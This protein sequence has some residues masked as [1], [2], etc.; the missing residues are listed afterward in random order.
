[1]NGATAMS[2]RSVAGRATAA[3]LMCF[4]AAIA[5]PPAAAAEVAAN[6]PVKLKIAF[7]GDSLVD[8][9]WSGV[10]RIVGASACLRNAIELGRYAKNG[11]GLTR[12]DRLYWPRE[13]RRIGEVFKPTVIVV[14]LGVND[15]QFIVDGAGRHTAWG[16]PDWPAKYRGEVDDFLEGAAA[17]GAT[18]L[19]VGLP[20]MREPV[21]NADARGKNELYAAEIAKLGDRNIEYV[22]PW[23][24]N[25][26]GGDAFASFGPDRSGRMVQIR[27]SDGQHFTT[28]GEDLAAAHIYPK[29]VAALSRIGVRFEQCPNLEARKEN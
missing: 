25:A 1:M 7:A 15:R 28:A 18:V 16:S 21:D 19:W 14:S 13:I 6:G 10:S 5:A 3:L 26:Q 9:Y 8:N 11:T 17:T 20:V 24:L 23:T 27:T 22:G 4:A 12:G 29:I 2:R